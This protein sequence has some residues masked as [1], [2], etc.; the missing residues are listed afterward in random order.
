MLLKLEVIGNVGQDCQIIEVNSKKV[1][2]FSVAHSESY[3]DANGV[4]VDKT[5]W[6]S[7]SYFALSTDIAPYLKKGTLVY[8]SGTPFARCYQDKN[9]TLVAQQN[10]RVVSIKLLG[11]SVGNKPA[12]AEKS[13]THPNEPLVN[14]FENDS[15][16]F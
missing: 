12:S 1:L 5:T 15:L 13:T 11:G 8:V 4:K 16:P 14:G 10:L 2:S 6:V 7:C 9:G 3:K